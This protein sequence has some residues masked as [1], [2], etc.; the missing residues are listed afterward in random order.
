ARLA[1]AHLIAMAGLGDPAQVTFLGADFNAPGMEPAPPDPSGGFY[2]PEPY[3]GQPPG[4]PH[5][6]FQLTWSDDPAERT[7]VD[8][9]AVERLRR[10]GL[11]DVAWHLRCP[12]H[13][14]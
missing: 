14:T 9:R 3:A 8:R 13:A 7:P 11:T 10:A 2:D 6:R 4:L 12:W 1:E 5:Q